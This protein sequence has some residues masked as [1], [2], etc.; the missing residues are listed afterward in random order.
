M[1][2]TAL[3]NYE[4]DAGTCNTC[5]GEL[6]PAEELQREPARRAPPVPWRQLGAGL[7]VVF[8]AVVGVQVA[9][10]V[11]PPAVTVAAR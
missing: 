3:L 8:L 4:D 5:P 9:N 11:W 6:M 10:V 2:P 1:K 7:A